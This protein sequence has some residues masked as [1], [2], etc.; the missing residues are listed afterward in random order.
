MKKQIL[1]FT[2]PAQ[3][4]ADSARQAARGRGDASDLGNWL[5]SELRPKG[6][7]RLSRPPARIT[8]PPPDADAGQTEFARW[9]TSDLRP[10]GGS[11]PPDSLAPQ[12]LPELQAAP[13]AGAAPEL[14]EED[15]SVL[16]ARP[17]A[18]ALLGR[19][20]ARSLA[21]LGVVVLAFGFFLMRGSPTVAGSPEATVAAPPEGAAASAVLLPP[22][23]PEPEPIEPEAELGEVEPVAVESPAGA[24]REGKSGP[25][26]AM[27]LE[28]MPPALP[29]RLGDPRSR[30][31]GPAV[32]RFADLPSPRLS[33]L[34]RA[35][36]QD[37][38]ERDEAAREDVERSPRAAK[39]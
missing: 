32:A 15:L 26:E 17:R 31:D 38:R 12:V 11:L 8:L 23:P 25:L 39:P 20:E 24:V 37:A 13:S 35:G 7:A 22:P 29:A 3:P 14:E 4:V 5:T 34:A 10:R 6:A 28:A 27:P 30:L 33:Q 2:P 36:M 21:A 18:L 9:L 1:V 16:P 19:R